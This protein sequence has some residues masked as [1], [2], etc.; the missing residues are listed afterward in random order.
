M[1]SARSFPLFY[2][3]VQNLFTVE[4]FLIHYSFLYCF[5]KVHNLKHISPYINLMPSV[6]AVV[7]V[8][9]KSLDS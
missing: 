5:H 4:F 3:D 8:G 6:F 1:S 2:S 7:H 9:L